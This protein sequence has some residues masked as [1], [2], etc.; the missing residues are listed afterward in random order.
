MLGDQPIAVLADEH[1]GIVDTF[2]RM[3]DGQLLTF[4]PDDTAQH[5]IDQ[6]TGS[7][8]TIKGEAI[9]GPLAGRQLKR[10]N[11]ASRVFWFIWANFNPQTELSTI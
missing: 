9:N 1:Q 3:V 4:E 5:F 8:W 7:Q 6:Q 2:E 10:I 11:H